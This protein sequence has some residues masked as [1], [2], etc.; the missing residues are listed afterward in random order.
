MSKL[1]PHNER[2][3]RDFLRHQK[4]ALGKCFVAI[5]RSTLGVEH[6]ID[7]PNSVVPLPYS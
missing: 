3:K 5:F 4:D 6:P 2:I 1:N 7:G